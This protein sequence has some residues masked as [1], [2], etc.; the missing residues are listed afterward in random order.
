MDPER[1]RDP[2][3]VGRR[4][5]GCMAEQP[6]SC[7]A[8]VHAT[9]SMPCIRSVERHRDPDHRPTL[10]RTGLAHWPVCCRGRTG[11][12]VWGNKTWSRGRPPVIN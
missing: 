1:E 8:M 4:M 10:E 6:Q 9:P 5:G 2:Q 7:E 3:M 12:R 11:P